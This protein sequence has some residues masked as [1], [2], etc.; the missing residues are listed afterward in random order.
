MQPTK[1]F[2]GERRNG[3]AQVT[4]DGEPLQ[5]RWFSRDSGISEFAWGAGSPSADRLAL[6]IL[7]DFLDH[8][9]AKFHFHEFAREIIEKLPP[10]WEISSWEIEEWL[11]HKCAIGYSVQSA[12]WSPDSSGPPKT[13]AAPLS[14]PKILYKLDSRGRGH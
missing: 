8:D 6:S 4:V 3:Q 13:A 11:D 10:S 2:K 7:A 14:L 12:V 1:I 5:R 9:R